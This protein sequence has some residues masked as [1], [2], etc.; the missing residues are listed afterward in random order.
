MVIVTP[1]NAGATTA[2]KVGQL[3]QAQLP[4]DRNWVYIGQSGVTLA[5]TAPSG[6]H[7]SDGLYL[8]TFRAEMAGDATLHFTGKTV[9]QANVPCTPLAFTLNFALRVAA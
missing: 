9:C 1:S 7:T 2:V 6:S 4:Y 8:W 5:P 3:V